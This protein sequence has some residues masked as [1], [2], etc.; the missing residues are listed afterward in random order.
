MPTADYSV[1]P[2]PSHPPLVLNFVVPL[3][4]VGIAR[5]DVLPRS[6]ARS[7]LR[8]RLL[9]WCRRLGEAVDRAALLARELGA[10][11]AAGGPAALVLRPAARRRGLAAGRG[12]ALDVVVRDV[13]AAGVLRVLGRDVLVLVRVGEDDVPGVQEAGQPAEDAEGDVDEGVGAADAAF[14]PDW[15]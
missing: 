10:R 1:P 14:D 4:R 11:R 3:H 2:T 5:R 13:A 6:A 15:R 9:L 12:L 8:L 7:R